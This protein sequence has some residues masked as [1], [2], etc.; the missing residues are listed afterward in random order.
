MVEIEYLP[1]QKIVIHEVRKLDVP[2]LLTLVALQVEAQKAGGV[3]VINWVDGIAFMIGEFIATPETIS[4]S[5]KGVVH[6]AIVNFTETSYQSEKRVTVNNR[7]YT[8]R[9]QKADNNP[10]FVELSKFLKNFKP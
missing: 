7:D 8:I 5:L 10:N 4:E 9:L 3:G 1:Y 6:Y 2:D